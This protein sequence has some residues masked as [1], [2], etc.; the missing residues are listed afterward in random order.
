MIKNNQIEVIDDFLHQDEFNQILKTIE[1]P[2]FPWSFNPNKVWSYEKDNPDD[3]KNFQFTHTFYA[4][5]SPQSYNFQDLS[6]LI[7]KIDPIGISKIKANLTTRWHCIEEFSPHTDNKYKYE[8]CKTAI[9]YLNTNDGYTRFIDC[10]KKVESIANR[11]AI[12]PSYLTHCGTT[13][14]NSK[15]RMVINLNYFK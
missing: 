12:F 14:T 4:N 5:F 13:H 15:N 10:D 3:L 2:T 6:P 1:S 8:N 9:Y 11:L 7:S